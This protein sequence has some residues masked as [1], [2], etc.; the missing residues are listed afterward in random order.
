MRKVPMAENRLRKSESLFYFLSSLIPSKRQSHSCTTKAPVARM[1][2]NKAIIQSSEQFLSK[3]VD[4]EIEREKE[5]GD[6]I[7]GGYLNDNEDNRRSTE[8]LANEKRISTTEP[9]IVESWQ[10]INEDNPAMHL[11]E[12]E[13]IKA[14]TLLIAQDGDNDKLLAEVSEFYYPNF[15]VAYNIVLTLKCFGIPDRV[16]FLFLLSCTYEKFG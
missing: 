14:V 2:S 16:I 9:L 10:I 4:S 6:V 12:T 11:L 1:N 3:R 8:I 7:N 13:T 5:K 15:V